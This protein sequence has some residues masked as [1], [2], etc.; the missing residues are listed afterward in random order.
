MT[1]TE[2]IYLPGLNGLRAIAA[3]AVVISHICLNL[4]R[5]GLPGLRGLDAANFGVTIFFSLSGFLITYLL[6]IEKNSSDRIAIGKFYIRRLA[7]I[8][9]LY[10]FYMLLVVLYCGSAILDKRMLWYLLFTPNVAFVIG[11]TVPLLV[12]YW[13][14]GV[15]EQFYAVWPWIVRHSRKLVAVLFVFVLSFILLKLLLKL[16]HMDKTYA[17]FHYSRFGCM[18][19]G[20]I[21]AKL[22][23]DGHQII[24][25]MSRAWVQFICWALYALV[26]LNQFHIASII[27]HEIVA[28]A[29]VVIIL[30]QVKGVGIFSLEK[31]WLRYLGKISFG[32]YVYNPLIIALAS[33]PITYWLPDIAWLKFML[34]FAVVPVA[35]V[36]VSHFSYRYLESTFLH[37]KEKFAVVKT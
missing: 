20:A 17:F 8:W 6:L 2:K 24:D 5:F 15:E 26:A 7:R 21:A 22:F 37:W 34:V 10:F 31:S 9:P 12:H 25:T 18:A 30:S 3:T 33:I 36:V 35:V 32:M 28:L 4:P 29:T 16:T 1:G 14:L 13:S 27:D 19:I 23:K 11:Q